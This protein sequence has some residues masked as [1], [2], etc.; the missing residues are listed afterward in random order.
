M[1]NYEHL[2][3]CMLTERWADWYWRTVQNKHR[4]WKNRNEGK[5]VGCE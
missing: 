3:L 5:Y 2:M 4:V 1:R